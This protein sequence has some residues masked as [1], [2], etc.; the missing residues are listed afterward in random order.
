M[1]PST[2]IHLYDDILDTEPTI[3]LLTSDQQRFDVPRKL[4]F[5]SKFIK[6]KFEDED[7]DYEAEFPLT[8]V[9][10]HSQYCP[11]SSY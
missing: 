8:T 3:P 1:I 10:S 5:Y 2:N 6:S 7:A 11:P 9:P 4:A